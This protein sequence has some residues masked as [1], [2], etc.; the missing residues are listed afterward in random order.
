MIA[1]T[2][3][4]K[5]GR[6]L[7]V[8]SD[9]QQPYT[10]YVNDAEDWNEIHNYI[11]NENNIDDIPNRKID[12]TSEMKC[13]LKRSVYEMSPAEA[14][15][16]RKHPKIRFVERST[17]YNEY[18]LEQRKYD[19]GFDKFIDAN[20]YKYDVRNMRS[21][22]SPVTAPP[23]L[24]YTQWGLYRHSYRA[25]KFVDAGQVDIDIPF[26]LSGKNV[27]VVIMDTG[28]RW[29]HPEFLKPGYTSVPNNL[30]CENESRVRDILIHGASD[31]G[32]NW[33]N[34]GLVAPG[35]GTLSNYNVTGALL[36]YEN[37]NSSN[38]QANYHGCHCAGTAAGNQF[39]WA[40]ESNIW[41]I[42]C[43]DRS[44]LGWSDPCDAFDYIR[45]WHKNKPINP[46]TG[47][48][49]PTVVNGSWGFRQ[50]FPYA[51]NYDAVERGVSFNKN[52][53][54]STNCPSVYYMD[55]Y[56]SW[57]E[58]TNEAP[59]SQA[60]VDEL[61]NDPDC[62]D[63]IVIFA[64]G[65]SKDKQ[66]IPGG[67][68]YDNYISNASFVYTS[69]R[70]NFYNR[71]G[72]PAIAVDGRKDAPISVGAMDAV[73][74]TA[75]GQERKASFS[76]SGPRID[77]WAAGYNILSPYG[78]GFQDPRNNNFFNANLN[79]TSM[80]APQVCGVVALYLQS[81][82]HA[83]RVD[84]RNWIVTHGSTEVPDTDATTD[85][86]GMWDQFQSNS[87]T[88]ADYWGQTYSLKSASRRILY[89]PFCNDGKASIDGVQL[90]GVVV[91]YK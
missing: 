35:T 16:L 74:A 49:N 12:C 80:A 58:F 85:T 53:M 91:S 83:D 25:N 20:R 82:P 24:D 86:A 8:H 48:R 37:G 70:T 3:D 78:S 38:S 88:D 77:V 89:N 52:A 31:Y 84:V 7:V 81:Q 18:V 87:I 32:I 6:V 46:E 11:I 75:N 29:D 44:D 34:E 47:R 67:I 73:T 63:L 42:A 60:K 23:K 43:I 41:N 4:P 36:M 57:K 27:D 2:T 64:A 71:A 13:S 30:T 15:V 62:D 68:D 76:N 45:V 14:E 19:E 69:D 65:N 22:A 51:N 17:L 66:D 1:T 56:Y 33:T 9:K 72:T 5:T 10:V 90:K 40:F 21:G 54:T 28:V 26:T 55:T 59:S 50:F 39:G 79:G 61:F